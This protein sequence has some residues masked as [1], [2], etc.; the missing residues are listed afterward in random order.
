MRP[1]KDRI[2]SVRVDSD[3]KDWLRSSHPSNNANTATSA[4]IERTRLAFPAASKDLTTKERARRIEGYLFQV[5]NDLEE[6][7]LALENEPTN[8][9][10]ADGP[11]AEPVLDRRG[12]PILLFTEESAA[13]FA[14]EHVGPL[15][16]ALACANADLEAAESHARMVWFYLR[17]AIEARDAKKNGG[18]K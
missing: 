1:K 11:Q 10:F 9:R 14:R 7:V 13:A 15:L 16:V 6:L 17:G 2:L 5:A 12:A 4:L 18:A 3:T 8:G